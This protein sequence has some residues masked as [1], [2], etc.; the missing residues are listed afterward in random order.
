MFQKIRGL[1][2]R[3]T[4]QGDC[5]RILKIATSGGLIEA[6]CYGA[7]RPKSSLAFLN[8]PFIYAEFELKCGKGDLLQVGSAGLIKNFY[9]LRFS[10]EKV[11]IA[12]EICRI[13]EKTIL[14]AE[15]FPLPLALNTLAI[16]EQADE[17]KTKLILPLFTLRYLSDI[18]FPAQLTVDSLQSTVISTELIAHIHNSNLNKLFN[19][20]ID[21]EIL[22]D[23]SFFA[24]SHA[25]EIFTH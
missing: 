23:L 13:I 1:V 8:E 17:E 5:N 9:N 19:I 15:S 11:E 6:I 14:P 12:A 10:L 16:L 22:S 18:G 4:R 20:K 2:V 7:A 3:S 21:S 25:K 24:K